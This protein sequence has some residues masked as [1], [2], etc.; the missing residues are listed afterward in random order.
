MT[1]QVHYVMARCPEWLPQEA[2]HGSDIERAVVMYVFTHER[3][4]TWPLC[5][6]CRWHRHGQTGSMPRTSRCPFITLYTAGQLQGSKGDAQ[7]ACA[8]AMCMQIEAC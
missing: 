7:P 8:A 3:M 1:S 5:M 2:A 6:V 4:I